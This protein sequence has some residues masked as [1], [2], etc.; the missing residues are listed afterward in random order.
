V[1]STVPALRVPDP[2][3]RTV[4]PPPELPQVA[5]YEVMRVLGRG[6]MGVVYLAWQTGL[7]RLVALK[8][9]LAGAHAGPEERARFRTE[10]EAAARLVHP[11]IVQIHEIGEAHGQPFLAMEYV[12]GGSL[13]AWLDGMPQPARAAAAFV[14]TLA[15]AVH[16][17]HQRGIIHRDLKPAN[18]LLGQKSLVPNPGSRESGSAKLDLGQF[19]P[20]ITDF[21]LAKLVVGGA[22]QTVSGTILGTPAYMAPEQA[23]GASAPVGPAAD[24]HSLGAILYELLTGR[25]PYQATSVLETLEQ[26]RRQEPVAP[27][28][29]VST[30]PRDLETAC[31]KCLHKEPARRYESALALAEDLRRYQAGEPVRARPVAA[32]ERGLRWIRRHPARAAL[33]AVSC[34]AVLALTGAVVGLTYNHQLQTLNAGLEAAVGQAKASRDALG[35]LERQVSYERDIHLADE[36]WHN[37]HFKRVRELLDGCPE[38]LRGWEWHYLYGQARDG[39][40]LRHNSGVLA[41]AFHPDNR[42][43]ASGCSDG[44]VWFWDI[45]TKK[46]H[47]S[48]ERHPGG[49]WSVAFS[50]DGRLLASAGEDRLVRLWNADDGRLL[51]KLSGHR[52][53]VRCVAFHPAGTMLA[54]AGKDG[55]IRLWDPRREREPRTLPGGHKG[56]VLALAFAHDGRTLASGGADRMVRL[57]DPDTGVEVHALP[58][59]TGDVY[60]L[61]FSP[62]GKTLASADADGTLRTW[63]PAHGLPG[64]AYLSGNRS[65]I[66]AVAFGPGGRMATAGDDHHVRLWEGSLVRTFRGHIHQVQGVAF[67]PDGRTMASASLD[68]TVKLWK[69]DSSQE[70]RAFPRGDTAILGAQ[71]STDKRRLT[72]VAENGT[73][74]TWDVESGKLLRQ[75][76]ARPA[77]L[78]SVA[79]RHDGRLLATAGKN[80]MVRC[81]DLIEDRAI[82]GGW[83]HNLTARAVALSPDG[84]R[85]ASSGDDKTVKIGDTAGEEAP[86]TCPAHD[87][88]IHAVAISPDGKTLVTGGEDDVR[89]LDAETGE[90]L[91]PL[92]GPTPKAT[93]FAFG[94]NGQLAVAQMG[95]RITL[96]DFAARRC[97]GTLVGHNAAVWSLAFT[98]DGTRLASAS[99][100]MTVRLWDTAS[101]KEVLPLQGFASEVRGV[102]FSP[103]G[104]RL[105]TTDQAGFVKLWEIEDDE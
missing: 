99:R 12:E 25:P 72:D 55:T 5:G 1:I 13:A 33:L 15:E 26:V 59:H 4:V 61:A 51:G 54:S 92:P 105:V 84:R 63:D 94:R 47:F 80:G 85:L 95:G 75:W 18:I 45:V 97:L 62:D 98:P 91:P 46:R 48:K 93:A 102:A 65:A 69:T 43:L 52:L 89:L 23:A 3:P 17:A 73:I 21:S 86:L 44:S 49:V 60:G 31:L 20:K 64:T 81:W 29:L 30:I 8:T 58:G 10:A 42:H 76:S 36:A 34:L 40:S 2:R 56:G 19:D 74:R 104:R 57:W 66:N 53:A 27:R 83:Q 24:V 68:F 67:S 14:A 70:Y 100:D 9:V 88:P 90:E 77:R 79:F 50:P 11:H 6:G 41:V 87:V 101:R 39:D 32:W 82:S 37:G 78:R 7:S 16:H 103:D 96:W 22:S 71:F 35:Q 28:H 38:D